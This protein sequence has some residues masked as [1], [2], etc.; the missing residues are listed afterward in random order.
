MADVETQEILCTDQAE[1]S[2]HDFGLFKLSVR[3]IF[4][5]I[6]LLADSGYQGLPALH[7][8]SRIPFKKSKNHPLTAEQ[9]SFNRELS[10]ERIVIE[11]IN[12]RI[13]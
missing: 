10:R 1:G 13:K 9:K 7:K 2:V 4:W 8:N 6:L 3:G 11:N 5:G 12:A